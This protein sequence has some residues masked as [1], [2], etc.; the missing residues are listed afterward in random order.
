[1]NKSELVQEISSRTKLPSA[2]VAQVVDA[3]VRSVQQHVIRGDKVVLS[4]FGT[5]H[6]KSRARRTARNVWT[7]QPLTLPA[8]NVPAFKPGKPFREAVARRRRTR[9]KVA[10]KAAAPGAQRR[11]ST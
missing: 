8:T 9:S 3:F 1:M 10:A 7:D 6:R 5:F 4:G 2:E 11:K